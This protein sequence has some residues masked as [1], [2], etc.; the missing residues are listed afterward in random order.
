MYTKG[1]VEHP[2]R[3]DRRGG[4]EDV[5]RLAHHANNWIPNLQASW[6]KEGP[7]LAQMA[8]DAGC[9]DFMGTLIN[10]SISTSAGAHYGQRMGPG[11]MRR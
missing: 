1:L 9:N 2:P 10:E 8:L 11:E 3:R 6:V 7:K 4:D 5:R